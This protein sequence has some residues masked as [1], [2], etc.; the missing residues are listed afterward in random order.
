MDPLIEPAGKK[1]SCKH[2]DE[3]ANYS[4][5]SI[6]DSQQACGFS[7]AQEVVA[8]NFLEE[9][10]GAEVMARCKHREGR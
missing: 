4:E 6:E 8:E 9:E 5:I 10:I 2:A 7:E 1:S 3:D